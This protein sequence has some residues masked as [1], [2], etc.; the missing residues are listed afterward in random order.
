MADGRR[1]TEDETRQALELYRRTPFSQFHDRN[2]EV[3]MLAKRMNRSAASVAMKLGNFAS[4][5]P[6]VT[7][8]GRK[9]LYNASAQDR[10]IWTE[11]Q[12]R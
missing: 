11:S 7:R 4:L 3:V 6:N 2:P 12:K 1:W 8:T 5:D 9:G 10:R